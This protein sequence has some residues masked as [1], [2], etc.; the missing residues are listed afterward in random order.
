MKKFQ[1]DENNSDITVPPDFDIDNS[2]P[3]FQ[4]AQDH[5]KDVGGR[6]NRNGSNVTQ[7]KIVDN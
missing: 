7:I 6:H 5:N 3:G 1:L 4:I 2:S